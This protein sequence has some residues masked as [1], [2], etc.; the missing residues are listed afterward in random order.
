HQGPVYSAVYSPTGTL[1]ATASQDGSIR[2]WGKDG[3]FIREMT[4]HDGEVYS[5]RFSPDGEILASAGED[6]TIKLW[7]LDGTPITTLVGHTAS[8]SDIDFS[9]DGQ[10]LVSTSEDGQ[11]LVWDIAELTSLEAL[12]NEGCDLLG[13][14]VSQNSEDF[15][16]LCTSQ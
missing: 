8:V 12:M 1:I 2:L 14:F 6:S 15:Q 13:E 7:Q 5:V 11:V 4:G 10:Q 16:E 9:K 3:R